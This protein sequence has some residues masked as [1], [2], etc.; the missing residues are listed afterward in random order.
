MESLMRIA[1]KA[2]LEENGKHNEYYERDLL[3]R[4]GKTEEL[5]V[6]RDR[7]DVLRIYSNLINDLSV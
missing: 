7:D 6:F 3:T 4:Y 1:I 2:I 5:K